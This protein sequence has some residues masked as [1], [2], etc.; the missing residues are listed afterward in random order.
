[1]ITKKPKQENFEIQRATSEKISVVIADDCA[2]V[3]AGLRQ[4]IDAEPDLMVVA[5]AAD[6]NEVFQ[7]TCKFRP[8]VVILAFTIERKDIIHLISLIHQEY[9]NVRILLFTM[10]ESHKYFPASLNAGASGYLA[11][12]ATISELLTAIRVIHQG[13]AFIDIDLDGQRIHTMIENE[14]DTRQ[15]KA[16]QQSH[17]ILSPREREVLNGIV[18]GYTNQQVA[19][20]LCLSVKSVETYRLRLKE[21]LGIQSR[22]ELVRFAREAGLF[23]EMSLD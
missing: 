4:L 6:C 10:Y 22:A 20:H 14:L 18:Q 12:N 8:N 11:R 15:N 3:R 16:E 23:R 2:I 9:N 1:M 21:K 7:Q 13:R 5:E 19:D 17:E